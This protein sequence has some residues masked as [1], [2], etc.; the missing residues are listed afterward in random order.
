MNEEDEVSVNGRGR[1]GYRTSSYSCV[2][3]SKGER[4]HCINFTHGSC[5]EKWNRTPLM[6]AASQGNVEIAELLLGKNAEVQATDKVTGL[7]NIV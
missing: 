3:V 4:I 6:F 7:R 5:V 1:L 2:D